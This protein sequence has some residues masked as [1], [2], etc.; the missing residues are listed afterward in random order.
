MLAN[1]MLQRVGRSILKSHSAKEA[2]FRLQ[3]NSLVY[4]VSG[5]RML[6]KSMSTQQSQQSTIYVGPLATVAKRLKLF[7]ISSL[8]LSS[9]ITPFVFIMDFPVPVFA[10]VVL[11]GSGMLKLTINLRDHRSHFYYY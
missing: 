4:G 1:Y 6:T 11:V 8:G 10:K 2:V 5:S 3:S 7:S 9:A